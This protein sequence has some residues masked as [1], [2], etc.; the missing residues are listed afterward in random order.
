[1]RRQTLKIGIAAIGLLLPMLAAVGCGHSGGDSAE[2][3]AG[4]AHIAAP[5][6]VVS[7]PRAR[8]FEAM[9]AAGAA[10]DAQR[11]AAAMAAMT[12]TGH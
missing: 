9:H 10:A 1:M 6:A 7:D 8:Q 11:R 3:G 4:A 5:A 2:A 12:K